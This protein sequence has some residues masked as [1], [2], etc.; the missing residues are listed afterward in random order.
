MEAGDIAAEDMTRAEEMAKIVVSSLFGLGFLRGH[1]GS[2]ITLTS[3]EFAL[4]NIPGNI[5]RR[6]VSSS[7]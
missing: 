3:R 4:A 1:E 5:G 7:S 6:A 2:R